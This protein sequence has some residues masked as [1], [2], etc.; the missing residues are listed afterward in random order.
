VEGR[1]KAVQARGPDPGICQHPGCKSAIGVG[2][3]GTAGHIKYYCS[4]HDHRAAKGEDMDQDA[5]QGTAD[6]PKPSHCQYR[7]CNSS[8]GIRWRKYTG[9]QTHYCLAH[10]THVR[11]GSPMDPPVK[12][13]SARADKTI[14]SEY[15]IRGLQRAF[16]EVR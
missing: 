9:H 8:H 12:L 1:A 14:T 5:L 7:N 4:T 15:M 16:E 11:K 13:G 3:N 2:W 6:R 10:Y